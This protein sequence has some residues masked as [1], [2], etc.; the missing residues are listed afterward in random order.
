VCDCQRAVTS[1][2]FDEPIKRVRM[3]NRNRSAL[4]TALPPVR[5][6]FCCNS[7]SS[8]NRGICTWRWCP[9]PRP[10]YCPA[11]TGPLLADMPASDPA[12]TAILLIGLL[13]RKLCSTCPRSARSARYTQQPMPG[14]EWCEFKAWCQFDVCRSCPSGHVGGHNY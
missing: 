12:I 3:W 1:I 2:A 4:L 13:L 5:C 11:L 14:F 7:G 9:G 6:L 10:S 8:G